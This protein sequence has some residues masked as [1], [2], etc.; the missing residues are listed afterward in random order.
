MYCK[1]I[2][3]IVEITE[4][5][6]GCSHWTAIF[7]FQLGVSLYIVIVTYQVIKKNVDSLEVCSFVEIV[8]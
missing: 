4:Q 5:N 3:Q 8:T 2:D 1:T 7:V 6:Q